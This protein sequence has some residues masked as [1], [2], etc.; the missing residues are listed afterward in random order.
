[1]L[2]SF[3]NATTGNVNTRGTVS[4]L[5]RLSWRELVSQ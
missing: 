5:Q 4:T 3:S 2:I 1:M